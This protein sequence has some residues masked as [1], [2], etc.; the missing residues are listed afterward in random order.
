MQRSSGQGGFKIAW[1]PG[2]GQFLKLFKVFIRYTVCC[3]FAL[4]CTASVVIAVLLNFYIGTYIYPHN[5]TSASEPPARMP[6]GF[7]V[8]RNN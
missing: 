4:D 8:I 3:L 2:S 5:S 1:L 7:D 6:G